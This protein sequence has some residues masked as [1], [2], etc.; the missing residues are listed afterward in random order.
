MSDTKQ[1]KLL[2][3]KQVY[4]AHIFE[5]S[6][7]QLLFPG[8]F[9]RTHHIVKRDPGAYVFPIDTD[10]NVY[11][12]KQ[13]RYLHDATTLESIAGLVDKDE[14]S[15]DAAKRE[16]KEEAGV[17]AKTWTKLGTF[18]PAGSMITW[19]QNLFLAQDLELGDQELE[20]TENI[21][22]VKIPIDEAVKK[23]FEGEICVAP[24]ATGIL[25]IDKLRQQGKI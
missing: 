1:V 24:T 25:M 16:L 15:L 4:K 14:E 8:G 10:F 18:K 22:V 6:E 9:E 11:L 23:I 7:D 19:D 20:D 3:R 21:Q 5:V 12:V 2:S 13:Y 17:T